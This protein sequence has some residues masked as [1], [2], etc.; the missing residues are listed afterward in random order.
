MHRSTIKRNRCRRARRASRRGAIAVL[1]AFVLV[2]LLAIAGLVLSMAYLELASAELQAAT[3]AAARSAVIQMAI[4]Q[5]EHQSRQAAVDIAGRFR[6][7]GQPFSIDPTDVTF[8]NSLR[9][10]D[11]TYS[12]Q[13]AGT[14]L[15][16]ARIQGR[17]QADSA[18]SDI[19]LPLGTFIGQPRFEMERPAIAMR[20]DYDIALVL[21]R[22][23]S[24]AWDL[25]RFRFSYPEG[26][27]HRPLLERYFSPPDPEASRWAILAASVENFLQVVSNRNVS[28]H[29]GL[30]TFASDYTFGAYSSQ[31]ATIDCDFTDDFATI[32]TQVDAIGST[33]VIGG[34][35]I[36]AGL[37]AAE[38]LLVDSPH[39]RVRTAHPTIVLFSDGIFTEGDDPTNIAASLYANHGIV[40]HSV[41]FGAD[42]NARE[43]MNAVAAAAGD[44]LSLHA[45][46][47]EELIDSFR[48]IA[49]TIP[50]IL[51]Q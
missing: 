51:T 32:R 29:V 48:Q 22:S 37:A 49:T 43:T 36:A 21:D 10:S 24:M 13:A 4:T 25:S 2:A 41:T 20:L 44:G 15:N 16:A 33:P 42:E 50:V 18:A 34:T 23:G 47:A 14:P 40:I 38:G 17:K 30:V 5:S 46:D 45:D 6:V 27:S 39:A 26:N 12:F 19:E 35:D 7:G 11:G 9:Q 3:D 28:A 1:T 8:G 31:R